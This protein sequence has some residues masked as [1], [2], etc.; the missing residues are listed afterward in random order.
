MGYLLDADVKEILS[1]IRMGTTLPYSPN[2]GYSKERC[3]NQIRK[4]SDNEWEDVE[5]HRP[6]PVANILNDIANR[7]LS[8]GQIISFAE[9]NR[10]FKLDMDME[11]GRVTAYN[12]RLED[13]PERNHKLSS[14][15]LI[16]FR[17]TMPK[18]LV[19]A[20]LADSP[21]KITK[22]VYDKICARVSNEQRNA[23]GYTNGLLREIRDALDEPVAIV[24]SKTKDG[25]AALVVVTRVPDRAGYLAM[26]VMQK[27]EKCEDNWIA[28]IYGKKKIANYLINQHNEGNLLYLGDVNVIMDQVSEADKRKME[29]VIRN[30]KNPRNL[31]KTSMSD[32]KEIVE[33]AKGSGKKSPGL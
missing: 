15:S 20:G 19:D 11:R 1:Y 9:K 8:L 5:T 16:V 3:P 7:R 18:K 26:V 12:A 4:I 10:E 2:I 27:D 6:Y 29:T 13:V 25:D 28:S 23:H 17:E 22:F 24:R 21:A 30:H 14:D 31:E 32:I 33:R